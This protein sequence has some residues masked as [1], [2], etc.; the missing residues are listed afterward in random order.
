VENSFLG[1]S[2]GAGG[3]A[4]PPADWRFSVGA[5]TRAVLALIVFAGIVG[6]ILVAVSLVGFFYEDYRMRREGVAG[7]TRPSPPVR[8]LTPA[9]YAAEQAAMRARNLHFEMDILLHPSDHLIEMTVNRAYETVRDG[10]DATARI[11]QRVGPTGEALPVFAV[12]ALQPAVEIV[13]PPG[14]EQSSLAD[15]LAGRA[16]LAISL[17][18]TFWA[19]LRMGANTVDLARPAP[20]ACITI[21]S[22]SIWRPGNPESV[23]AGTPRSGRLCW[24]RGPA[25]P[26]DAT[27]RWVYL[28]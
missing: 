28:R 27:E 12:P 8:V 5:V 21:R 19:D 16:D 10:G 18:G 22:L 23:R 4:P 13:G 25:E 9:Q 24:Q 15:A 11:G 26:S 2:R 20:G 6:L 3:S 14:A 1:Y 17:H 7:F